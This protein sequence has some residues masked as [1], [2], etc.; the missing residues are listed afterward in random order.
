MKELNIEEVESVS[1]SGWFT[2]LLPIV[3][4]F[5]TGGPAGAVIGAGAVIATTGAKNLDHLSHNGKIP[6]VHE[7]IN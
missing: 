2:F 5:A 4:G 3:I 6:T 1:G 7:M